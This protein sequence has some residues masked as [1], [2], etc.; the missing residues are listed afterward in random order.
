MKADK[1]F[2]MA[3]TTKTLLAMLPFKNQEDRNHFK[4]AMIDAQLAS[5]KAARAPLGKNQKSGV[6][7]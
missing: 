3:K 1:N 4:R 5:E 7:E 6:D 2:R